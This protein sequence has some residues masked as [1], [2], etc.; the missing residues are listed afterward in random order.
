[1]IRM[2]DFYERERAQKAARRRKARRP[3][4]V[5]GDLIERPIL[6]DVCKRCEVCDG[7]TSRAGG[8]IM[9]DPINRLCHSCEDWTRRILA[10]V[11]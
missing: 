11:Y 5:A 8:S 9:G 3:W 4:G 10:E 6:T 1:M 2:A 7:I